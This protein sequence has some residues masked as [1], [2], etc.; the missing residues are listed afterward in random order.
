MNTTD[1]CSCYSRYSDRS[2]CRKRGIPLLQQRSD[3]PLPV[4]C[5]E[6]CARWYRLVWAFS[7]TNAKFVQVDTAASAPDSYLL[8][9]MRVSS[10]RL[11]LLSDDDC[12]RA[13][14]SGNR[15]DSIL[16]DISLSSSCIN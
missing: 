12:Q 15:L 2:G 14:P 9:R 11:S 8:R 10:H 6:P 5:I 4:L 3:V 13:H 7:I 16:R 1:N